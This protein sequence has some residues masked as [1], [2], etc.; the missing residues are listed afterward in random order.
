VAAMGT[1]HD[2]AHHHA[3]PAGSRGAAFACAVALNL[4]FVVAETG[5]GFYSGSMAL[6]ADAGHNLSDVLSLVLA[7][8]ASVL[9][10]R[11]PSERYTYGLKS[12]SILA[13]IANAALLWVAIGAILVETI[14]RFADPAPIASHTVVVVA[15]AG[16]VVNA[17][18]AL[19]FAR[20]SKHDLNVRAA[21]VH[22]MADAGVSAGVVVAG[23][24]IGATG[25]AW[26][27]PAASLVVTAVIAWSS[28]SLLRES[29]QLGMLAVPSRID[30]AEVRRFLEALP[31][32]S[33]VHDLHIWPMSTT[34]AALTA[35]LVIPGGAIDDDFLHEVAHELEHRFAIGHP[36]LQ[37]ETAPVTRCSLESAHVV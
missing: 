1:G 20:G 14:R 25:L 12:S 24:L 32:V 16:I 15:L 2:H 21:F 34:E 27:D 30:S 17:A 35:H 3:P 9:S 33:R 10:A 22:L 5:A 6:I 13:A 19:L 29:L 37:I 23:L 28:W 8:V 4:A 31:G 7:W 36:T 18:S 26:I 11:P